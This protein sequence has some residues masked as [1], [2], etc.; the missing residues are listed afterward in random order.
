MGSNLFMR[1]SEFD[2]VDLV[3]ANIGGAIELTKSKFNKEL[4]LNGIQTGK[5]LLMKN[6]EFAEI[7]LKGTVVGGT[8]RLSGQSNQSSTHPARLARPAVNLQLQLIP[9]S[10]SL[11]VHVVAQRGSPG[12]KSLLEDGT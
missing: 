4:I 5:S 6:S 10:R 2:E 9:P 12:S 1:Y 8:P 11:R 3:N 7:D